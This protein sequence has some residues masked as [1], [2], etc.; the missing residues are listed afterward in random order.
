MK[1]GENGAEYFVD[2]EVYTHANYVD[3][4]PFTPTNYVDEPHT[5]ANLQAI[6]SF[7]SFKQE[8]NT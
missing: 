3:D 1:V 7:S 8:N 2:D 5:P 4:E 6:P